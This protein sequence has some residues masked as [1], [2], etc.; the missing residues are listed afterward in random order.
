M[1][2]TLAM[3]NQI[4]TVE[5]IMVARKD[6][7]FWNELDPLKPVLQRAEKANLNV[8]PIIEEG[9]IEEVLWFDTPHTKRPLTS[10]RFL[11]IS[12]TIPDVIECFD[13]HHKQY[14]HSTSPNYV[15]VQDDEDVVVGIVTPSDLNKLPARTYFYNLLAKL[16]MTFAQVIRDYY[17]NDQSALLK[18]M[19]R[20]RAADVVDALRRADLEID[21][22]HFLYL[23]DLFKIVDDE[24]DLQSQMGLKDAEIAALHDLRAM[25]NDTMHPVRIM[26]DNQQGITDLHRHVQQMVTLIEELEG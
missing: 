15:F 18:V 17:G 3:L 13:R 1:P 25:R 11:P 20:E 21:V 6:F 22:V 2:L 9:E 5:T 4:F 19:P 24:N 26:L 12:A 7:I 14:A 10:E 8:I 23:T 16:E